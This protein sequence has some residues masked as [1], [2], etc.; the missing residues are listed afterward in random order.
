MGVFKN[1]FGNKENQLE[2]LAHNNSKLIIRC[3]KERYNNFIK[4]TEI[5][6]TDNN[7]YSY[8]SYLMF[9]SEIG[10]DKEAIDNNYN[11]YVDLIIEDVASNDSRINRD[12]FKKCI[13]KLREEIKFTWE[14]ELYVIVFMEFFA[15]SFGIELPDD[16]NEVIGSIFG[17][18]LTEMMQIMTA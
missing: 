9:L 13:L 2:T 7:Y 12:E 15:K 8:I 4:K 6:D 3:V 10:K 5:D 11:Y 18:E 1:I 14:K 17:E 16:P